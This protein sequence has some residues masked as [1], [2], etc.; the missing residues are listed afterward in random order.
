MAVWRS[1]QNITIRHPQGGEKVAS[2]H[3]IT[4]K[5][6]EDQVEFY[7][8]LK[9]VL[10]REPV[11]LTEAIF[12]KYIELRRTS[13]VA[14]WLNVKGSRIESTRGFRL[15]ISTDVTEVLNEPTAV[16]LVDN[17]V[18]CLAKRMQKSGRLSLKQLQQVF[19]EVEIVDETN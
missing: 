9:T 4:L 19:G 8:R 15:W 18:Y 7:Q 17:Q 1:S 12:L 13:D 3:S 5:S 16:E 11:N 6:L 2:K 14:A 10:S